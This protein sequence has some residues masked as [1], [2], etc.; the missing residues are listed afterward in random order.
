MANLTEKARIALLMMRGWGDRERS[1]NEIRQFFNEIFR[2]G[3]VPLS[4]TIVM[5]TIR[6]YEEIGNVKNR[7][8]P[9]R[10]RSATIKE[11]Q[12][13]V[14]QLFVE[15]PHKSLRKVLISST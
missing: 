3:G 14:A 10:P 15:N 8:I 6:R 1:Y 5:R 13:N 4:K 2:N 11:N 9:G 12:L 7:M